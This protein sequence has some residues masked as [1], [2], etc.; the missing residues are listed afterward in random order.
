MYKICEECDRTGRRP[1]TVSLSEEL[2]K[3]TDENDERLFK[4]DEWLSSSQIKGYVASFLSK[5]SQ[6]VIVPSPAKKQLLSNE[7]VVDVC[8]CIDEDEKLTE[9]VSALESNEYVDQMTCL[10]NDVFTSVYIQ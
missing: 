5:K 6:S 4:K 3:V 9:I 7:C 1:D 8:T 10:V 2:K